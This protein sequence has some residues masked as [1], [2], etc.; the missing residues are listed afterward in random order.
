[1]EISYLG[2]GGGGWRRIAKQVGKEGGRYFRN[3][4]YAYVVMVTRALWNF[5]QLYLIIGTLANSKEN[6]DKSYL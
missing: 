6:S 3:V 1:M 5:V 4:C 2:G